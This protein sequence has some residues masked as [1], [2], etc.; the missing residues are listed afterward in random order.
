MRIMRDTYTIGRN[1]YPS[2]ICIACKSAVNTTCTCKCANMTRV[3]K[4]HRTATNT[5]NARN[6]AEI[7]RTKSCHSGIHICGHP[8]RMLAIR[9]PHIAP[10]NRCNAN[11]G[12][13]VTAT[14]G[15]SKKD[16][17]NQQQPVTCCANKIRHNRGVRN[18]RSGPGPIDPFHLGLTLCN[19]QSQLAFTKI[20][21]YTYSVQFAHGL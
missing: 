14:V 5:N 15:G 9:K 11:T 17:G 21:T 4:G 18:R 3:S 10:N 20:F 13:Q 16:F 19:C 6:L 12:W 7:V 1:L 2:C 8:Q